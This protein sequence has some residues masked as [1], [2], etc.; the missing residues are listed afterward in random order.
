[1]RPDAQ[2]PKYDLPPAARALLVLALLYAFLVGIGL[3]EEG[4]SAL[5]SG[6]Q[7][8][9]LESVRNP[10][11]G[12]F[13]GILATVLVQS[14]S[15]STSTIVGLVGAGTL[16]LGAAVPMI[17][18]AN[19]GTTVTNTLASL[20]SIRRKDEFVRAFAGATM[21]DFFNLLAV[22]VF[23]P[24]ELAT[25]FL[26]RS[27][28]ALTEVL[29]GTGVEGGKAKSPIKEL[30]EAPVGLI[31]DVSH[32]LPTDVVTGVT[33][34]ALG[35]AFILVALTFITR[36]MRTLVAGTLERAMNRI[37]ASG[38]GSV[39]MVIGLA[40]TV[41][42]QSSSITTSILVPIVAAGVL[43]LR[44]AYP[45]TLGANVGTTV[46]ALI[47]SLAVDSPEGLTIAL[48]HTLFNISGIAVLYGIPG[49]RFLPV[50][51]AK[52]L[53]RTAV[54]NRSAVVGYV[55]GA[56]VVIPLGGMLLLQ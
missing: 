18:G 42:V 22:A 7:E 55:V 21:H 14:S 4:I 38:G 32:R 8:G 54:T 33:L 43:T 11:A 52:A 15:V 34:L 1:M 39:G 36:N 40:V 37:I 24:L 51:L 26:S 9:L 17:M 48:V 3:L 46:T 12:V 27:A 50:R 31:A 2:V 25:G 49:L 41:A 56:F 35:L 30:V 23:L 19:I 47:A 28:V 6:F 5:G 29:R 13:A 10:V 45:I 44:N 53:A 16:T 20:G